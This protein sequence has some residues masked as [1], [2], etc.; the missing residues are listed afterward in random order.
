MPDSPIRKPKTEIS[1]QVLLGDFMQR[2]FTVLTLL[3]LALGGLINAA[4]RAGT[5][6]I[7]TQN[8]DA[9]TDQTYIVAAAL[10]LIPG[11]TVADAVD[12][13][14]QELQASYIEQ[15]ADV[16]AAKIAEKQPDLVSLQEV[17]R[18]QIDVTS[19]IAASIVY[20]QLEFLLTALG[21]HGVPYEVVALNNVDDVTLPGKQV[22]AVRFTD[23][24]VLLVRSG[25][26][27]PDLHFSDVHTHTFG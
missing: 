27:P 10:N 8:M 19:P 17:T 16:L 12:L 21:A 23:R 6:T 26:G 13:T 11:F 20:D 9:G 24:D 14:A 3:S 7:L 5:V 22:S 15:R 18:W 2:R 1:V 4:D 25:L